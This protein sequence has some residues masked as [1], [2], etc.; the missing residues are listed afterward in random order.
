MFEEIPGPRQP[1]PSLPLVITTFAV[2][3]GMFV[4]GAVA[5][6]LRWRIPLSPV[7]KAMALE[8]GIGIP[9]S[10]YFLFTAKLGPPEGRVKRLNSLLMLILAFQVITDLLR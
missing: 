6:F 2:I 9:L 8:Y 10:G 7:H 1:L 5:A 3:F 4:I